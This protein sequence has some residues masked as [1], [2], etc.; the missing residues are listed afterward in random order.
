MVHQKFDMVAST[1]ISLSD[2]NESVYTKVVLI[3][4][5]FVLVNNLNSTLEV[6]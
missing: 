2:Y 6:G 3:S 5:K 4:P 1:T